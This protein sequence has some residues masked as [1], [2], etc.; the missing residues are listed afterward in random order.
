MLP[1]WRVAASISNG[2]KNE[3]RRPGDT[4]AT[5]RG[6]ETSRSMKR[7]PAGREALTSRSD[8]L[9]RHKDHT[10]HPAMQRRINKQRDTLEE[11]RKT[12]AEIEVFT[13]AHFVDF[14]TCL[15][16][17]SFKFRD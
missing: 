3:R 1:C 17:K 4:R 8:N 16:E 7:S 13:A 11:T 14:E 6:A 12:A 5:S 10:L 2:R 9:L 15:S